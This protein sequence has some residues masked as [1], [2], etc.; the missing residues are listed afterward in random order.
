M[1]RPNLGYSQRR[2]W[3]SDDDDRLR[4]L[5]A[6]GL[7][8]SDIANE[9][10]R[11]TST[12]WERADRAGVKIKIAV[13]NPDRPLRTREE[14][15]ARKA[16]QAVEAEKALADH[17]LKQKAIHENHERLKAERLARETKGD[18]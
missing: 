3:T 7:P 1:K 8:V 14:R 15:R 5:A 18:G 9:M 11:A 10:R 16:V 2:P 6:S 13:K 17:H 4:T 12:I